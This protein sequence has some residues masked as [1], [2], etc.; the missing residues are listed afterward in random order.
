MPAA[1]HPP[2]HLS[3]S[4]I[5]FSWS[6][7]APLNDPRCSPP[8]MNENVGCA[9]LHKVSHCLPKDIPTT[10]YSDSTIKTTSLSGTLLVNDL[11]VFGNYSAQENNHQHTVIIDKSPGQEDAVSPQLDRGQPNPYVS[12]FC[13][14]CQVKRQLS[15][16]GR[17]AFNVHTCTLSVPDAC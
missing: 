8:L 5:A 10:L 15:G 6:L 14:I 2:R 16:P 3:S 17:P 4:S 11:T 12:V 1:L 13:H 7:S 9:Q